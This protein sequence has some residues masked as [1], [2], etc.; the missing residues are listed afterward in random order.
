MHFKQ[1]KLQKIV[2]AHNKTMQINDL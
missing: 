1:T 2:N